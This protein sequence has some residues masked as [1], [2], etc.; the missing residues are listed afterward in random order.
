MSTIPPMFICPYRASRRSIFCPLRAFSSHKSTPLTYP[1]ALEAILT[2]EVRLFAQLLAGRTLQTSSI[3]IA[4]CALAFA[5]LVDSDFFCRGLVHRCGLN[6]KNR[7][8]GIGEGSFNR[9]TLG[10]TVLLV[11]GKDVVLVK[12]FSSDA[13][14]VAVFISPASSQPIGRALTM[15]RSHAD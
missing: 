3:F 14:P 1:V 10:T 4:V 8:E 5:F 6:V 15:L 11:I 13:R 12:V 7:L 9:S 2:A